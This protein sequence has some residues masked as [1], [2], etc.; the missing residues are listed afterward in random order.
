MNPTIICGEK[1]TD[2]ALVEVVKNIQER[3]WDAGSVGPDNPFWDSKV[4]IRAGVRSPMDPKAKEFWVDGDPGA[5]TKEAVID[6]QLRHIGP[7][8]IPLDETEKLGTVGEETWWAFENSTGDP[9]HQWIPPLGVTSKGLGQAIVEVWEHYIREGLTEIPLGSNRGPIIKGLDPKLEGGIDIWTGYKGKASRIKGPAW[10]CWSRTGIERE[11]AMIVLGKDSYF[12]GRTGLCYANYQW[13]K[14]KGIYA[15]KDDIVTG[16]VKLPVGAAMIMNY[17]GTRGHTGTVVGIKYKDD[18]PIQ[19]ETRE[20]NISDRA[21][22]RIRNLKSKTIKWFVI[23][24]EIT[25]NNPDYVGTFNSERK[26][27]KDN[28]KTR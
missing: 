10:C 14:K 17:G 9:Q 18:L 4:A 27:S 5:W 2:P 23:A 16:R 24:P 3:L 13:G 25:D 1:L 6:F 11:T 20:G 15:T 22:R 12:Q 8:K 26:I 19:I 28:E 7:N 21:G